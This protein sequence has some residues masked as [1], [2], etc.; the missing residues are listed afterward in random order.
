MDIELL[1]LLNLR[2]QV[3][4]E[5]YDDE[6][7]LWVGKP[8]PVRVMAQRAEPLLAYLVFGLLFGCTL[9]TLSIS[10]LPDISLGTV[11]IPILSLLLL[12]IA[13]LAL[14]LIYGYWLAAGIVYG[15][16]NRRALII[17]RALDGKSVLAYNLI[18]YLKRHDLAGGRG[19]LVFATETYSPLIPTNFPLSGG[20]YYVRYRNVGF[21][22]IVDVR[23]VEELMINTFR[24]AQRSNAD[25]R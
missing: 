15:I 4:A 16:T 13:G 25:K 22:G 20:S 23:R 8:T 10:G 18:T 14:Y 12:P 11:Q 19:D 2:E 21:F 7:L 17:E 24:P 1:Q 9:L 5:L 6:E 3:S